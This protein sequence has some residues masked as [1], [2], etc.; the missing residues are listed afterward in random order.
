MSSKDRDGLKVFAGRASRDLGRRI[1]EHL[2]LPPGQSRTEM[3]ADGE[4]I[5][6][7]DEDVRGRDCFVVQSTYHPVNAHLM[8]LLIHIDCL[9]RASARRVT[10]VLPYFG[11]ARQ[12]RKDE[13]RTPITAKL[14]ANLITTAGADRV[15]AMDLHAAQIQGFFDIP[16]D[17]LHAAPVIVKYL[18]AMREQMGDI[19][20][21]SPD[22]GNVKEATTYADLLGGDLAIIDKTRKSDRDV[23]STN[24]IGDVKGK[25]VVMIDDMISTAGTMCKAATL[26]KQNGATDVIAAA[27]HPVLVGLAI[28]RIAEAPITHVAVTD[29][30]PTEGRCKPIEDKLAVLTVA[31][32]LGEAIHRIHHNLSVSSLFRHHGK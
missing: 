23:E 11:Y 21:V 24:I 17:H 26:V 32:L 8:E 1:C 31:E 19:V 13:G 4:I 16:V 12:D 3:F 14:V 20:L 28:E 25:T 7:V 6:K 27:T 10:A 22:V 29:T 30:I 18:N 5:M 15:L 9:K 2:E